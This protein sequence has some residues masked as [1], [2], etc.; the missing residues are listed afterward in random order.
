MFKWDLI[1]GSLYMRS[2]TNYVNNLV[3]YARLPS[4]VP[5][6]LADAEHL[7]SWA[8]K[9]PLFNLLTS[10]VEIYFKYQILYPSHFC[11][12]ICAWT[13]LK[14]LFEM[15]FV[16]FFFVFWHT[17]VK[18]RL[19]QTVLRFHC[20]LKKWLFDVVKLLKLLV[21]LDDDY[22][23]QLVLVWIHCHLFVIAQFGIY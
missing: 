12:L 10:L 17:R 20:L 4:E 1:W 19:I 2:K 11:L 21:K 13:N 5:C 7:D 22:V 14:T 16:F 18:E 8:H 9:N 3:C 23:L 6:V 15:L